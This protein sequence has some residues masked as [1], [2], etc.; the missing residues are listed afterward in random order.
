[1]QYITIADATGFAKPYKDGY[2]S[3][4]AL[5]PSQ[6]V[7]LDQYI[8][9]LTVEKVQTASNSGATK[10]NAAIL[11]FTYEYD[12]DM[13]DILSAMGINAA[14]GRGTTD[15]S[16]LSASRGLY[17]DEVVHKTKMELSEEGAKAGAVTTARVTKGAS[18]ISVTLDHPFVYMMMDNT[19]NL[20]IF[21]GAVTD[22]PE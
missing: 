22:I 12:A 21:I 17:L 1:M 14:F 5:L 6:T 7:G 3:F 19:T 15:F 20:P 2:Y 8:S 18:T 13:N 16:G 4:V 10:V 9:S 11:K